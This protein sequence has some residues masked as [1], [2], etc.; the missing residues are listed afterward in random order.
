MPGKRRAYISGGINGLPDH[1]YP[2]FYKAAQMW[3]SEGWAVLNPAELSGQDLERP[4]KEYIANDLE[5]ILRIVDVI[6]VLPGWHLSR[7]ATLEVIVGINMGLEIW[8]AERMERIDSDDNTRDGLLYTALA[9]HIQASRKVSGIEPSPGLLI[10]VFQ[11]GDFTK[12][13]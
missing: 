11:K 3:R 10:D 12:C 6:A 7:G 4:W 1:N 2:A 8:C 9:S 13:S 5:V